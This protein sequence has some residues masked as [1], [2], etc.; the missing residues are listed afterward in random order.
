MENL[1]GQI[2][3]IYFLFFLFS[4][5]SVQSDFAEERQGAHTHK[6]TSMS[7]PHIYLWCTVHPFRFFFHPA[8][9]TFPK[10][11]TDKKKNLSRVAH[12]LVKGWLQ[13]EWRT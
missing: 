1:L 7:A 4:R 2:A 3:T 6:K 10:K 13:A 9:F 12:L 11:L 8:C 5:V